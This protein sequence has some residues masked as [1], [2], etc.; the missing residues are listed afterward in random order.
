MDFH[1]SEEQV[2]LRDMMKVFAAREVSPLAEHV[3]K[4]QEFP[5]EVWSKL[6]ELGI[7]NMN[8]PE[9]AGG[10]GA[11][12]LSQCLAIE[13][14]GYAD[15]SYTPTFS[16]QQSSCRHILRYAREPKRS[17]WIET[18]V[19]PICRG[20]AWGATALT[21][22]NSSS[23]DAG[24]MQTT[25]VRDG[26][27]WVIN[28]NKMYSTASGMKNTLFVI[29]WAIV[30]KQTRASKMF[31]VPAGTP[32]FVV[33]NK[34]P[35]LGLR[36]A[37]TR[38][39]FFDDCRVPLDHILDGE[40]SSDIN[41]VGDTQFHSRLFLASN[42]IGLQRFC[43][44]E[45]L[46]F[47]RERKT[48]GVPLSQRQLIQGWLAEMATDIEVST[49]LRDRAAWRY[50]RGEMT[51]AEAAMVKYVCAENALKAANYASDIFGG[52]GFMEGVPVVRRLRD[53]KGL[54]I[55]LGGITLF[56]WIIAR[57]LGCTDD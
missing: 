19:K 14:I 7:I 25:A 44:D 4:T 28:G 52:L 26:D 42:A 9:Q 16:A 2:A 30:D 11:D 1:Y 34:L 45:A 35:K 37:D 57:E 15:S 48:W 39:L 22:P 3:D 32:G 13:E 31:L 23:N 38:E 12:M 43:L 50:D 27:E 55:I 6:G 10:S 49:L 54:T 47:A 29:V 33:G 5:Y 46:R 17:E 36:G 24:S 20:E 41:P 56:K 53:A 21:E 40:N 8:F 18:Y 51:V